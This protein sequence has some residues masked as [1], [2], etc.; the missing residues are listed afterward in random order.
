MDDA[1]V[2]AFF[3]IS[4]FLT[5]VI[6]LGIATIFQWFLKRSKRS[7]HGLHD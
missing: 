2:A 3:V 5:T 4:I 6:C 1:F 7:N